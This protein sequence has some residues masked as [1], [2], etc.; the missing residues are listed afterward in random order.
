M[1]AVPCI[2]CGAADPRPLFAKAARNGEVFTLT[3]CRGCGLQYVNPRPDLNEIGAYYAEYFTTRTDRGYNDYFSEQT[4]RE[5][6][7]VTTLNLADLGFPRYEASLAEPRR[8][9]DI[10]C[11]AG[12]FVDYLTRR[13]WRAAGIDTAGDCIDHART[14]GLDVRAG[15]YLQA[16]FDES[17]HLV[18]LWATIEHLHRP[19][20]FLE[21][22]ARE[23]VP[24]GMLYIST[25]RAGGWNVQRLFGPSWRFY[26]FPEH[27]YFFSRRH[28]VRLLARHDFRIEHYA[29]YGSNLFPAGSLR[30]RLADRAV[31][32]LGLGDM[33]IVAARRVS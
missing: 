4:R 30:R 17:F 3:R 21:K 22:I 2:L 9:L 28:L 25:C 29:T 5:I 15:D 33:M 14:H 26:N 11:A 16:S 23:L 8:A 10:G 6:G 24:G 31:K 20:R 1:E 13:G 12:Y 27:L 32:A 7:R 19:D 18:T